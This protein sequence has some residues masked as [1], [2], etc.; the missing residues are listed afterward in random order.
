MNAHNTQKPD[1]GWLEDPEIFRVNRLDAHS[2]HICYANEREAEEKI[3]SLRQSLNGVWRFNWSK[4]P[5]SRPADFWREDY[6]S[7]GFDSIAV[8]SH[9]ELQGYD[10]IQYIN[11]LYPWDGHAE[12]RPPQTDP[13]YN[14]VGSYVKEFDLNESLAGKRICVS[15]QGVEQAFYL[16]LNGNFIGYAEDSF[17][18]SDFELTPYIKEKG[19]RLCAEVYKRSSAAWIEDQD[20][21][22]FS[23]I[24]RPV[25]LYAKP[26]AH[27]EDIWFKTALSEDNSTASLQI[28]LRLEGMGEVAC[29]LWDKD[30]SVLFEGGLDLRNEDGYLFSQKITLKNI[31]PWE[32]DDPCLYR[33]MLTVSKNGGVTE[34]VPY[35]IGFRRFE[36]KDGIMQLNGKR[37][38]FNG[39]NRHEWNPET[40]RAISDEDMQRAMEVFL[41]NNINAV[42]TCHYPNQSLWY[43]LCDKNGI[44]MIDEANLESH[45]SWQKLGRVEPSWNVPGSLPQWKECVTDR[46]RSM[47]ERDKNHPAI[48]LWSCGNESYAGEDIAAMADF[49]RSSDD[50]RLVHYEGVCHNREFDRISD[51]ES[52]MY[53]PPEEIRKYLM[54]DPK[55][56]FILC[57]YMHDMGNSLGGME[58]YI[59]LGEEFPQYQGGFIWDYMDQALWRTVDGER[60]LGYGGDFGDRQSDYNFSGNGIV[61]ADGTEK[62]AMQEVRYRYASAKERER[63]DKANMAAVVAVGS[64]KKTKTG[65]LKTVR[66]DGGL[67][68]KG[69]GFEIIFSYPEGGPSSIVSGGVEWL[70]RAPRPAYW[71]APTENDM[72]CGFALN[73]SVWSAADV[74]QSCN[75]AEIL[76]ESSDGVSIRFTYGS[77][78]LSGLRTDLT[79]TVNGSGILRIDVHYFGGKGFPPLPLLGLRF[80]TPAPLDFTEWT[81]LSGETYP[82]RKKGGVFG[83]H[84]ET[85]HITR[86]LVPQECG[87]HSDTA[88]MAL[89][90][91]G[92]KLRFYMTD[93]PFYFSAIPYTPQQLEQAAHIEELPKAVRTVV[94]VCGAMRGVGGIDSWGSDVEEEYRISGEKEIEFSAEIE[95]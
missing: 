54:S 95:L 94:T 59:R 57:E 39:V 82:D 81:G 6:D 91:E 22:R 30:G 32:H 90:R 8:P 18:P 7:S 63:H 33:I 2:D 23:G 66:G 56:P 1:L 65:A 76:H 78:A 64:R 48:L 89:C 12:L 21:F 24:F 87:C 26:E 43:E 51:V 4:N 93:K 83:L 47:F 46:A 84:R 86:Y 25:F 77:P 36:L 71:R 42:R 9:I 58:S 85:P 68:V 62:P 79:Y 50:S 67:G 11:T 55:K 88:E 27:I 45:G 74:Y 61:F 49:F 60:A 72:G 31:R 14:P 80:S 10:R 16:W 20:F 69:D 35:D 53:A 13:D 15:F 40:G 28:R 38:M 44:Y 17:T 70:W 5:D 29:R 41:K 73:S 75:N 92:K 37:I 19:N 34:A 52:R 3:T